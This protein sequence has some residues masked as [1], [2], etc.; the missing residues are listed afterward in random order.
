M[1]KI[2]LLQLAL[3]IGFGYGWVAN[4]IKVIGAD[5]GMITGMIVCRVIGIFLAPLGGIL[6]YF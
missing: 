6:G 5:F 4:L 3:I 1:G 2:L